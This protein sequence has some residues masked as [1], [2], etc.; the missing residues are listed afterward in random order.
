MTAAAA[1]SCAW[2]HDTQINEM[3]RQGPQPSLRDRLHQDVDRHCQEE[4][5]VGIEIK[6]ERPL[7]EGPDRGALDEAQQRERQ[8][9]NGGEQGGAAAAREIVPV[10]QMEPGLQ[11]VERPALRDQEVAGLARPWPSG[12]SSAV[13]PPPRA[14]D[15]ADRGALRPRQSV[16]SVQVRRGRRRRS[17]PRSRPSRGR[18]RLRGRRPGG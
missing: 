1:G 6:Q 9:G 15:V 18:D 14:S 2:R 10:Q 11:L 3:R 5:G 13:S 12:R 16:T 4:A 17:P 8:P 7:R